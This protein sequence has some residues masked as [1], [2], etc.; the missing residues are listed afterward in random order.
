MRVYFDNA[1]TTP[2]APEVIETVS[3]AMRTLFG[4]PSS[5]HADGR[6][7]RTA[8]ED[9]RKT[10][11]KYLN[12]SIGEIFF[13]SGG[14]ESNNMILKNA[15][16]DLGVK[17]FITSKIEHHCV[18]HTL[19]ALEKTADIQ[20]EF[21]KIDE[22]GQIDLDNLEVLLKINNDKTLVSLMHANNEIG[23]M[24]D[25]D[26]VS[27]ICE[28]NGALFH[29]DT[30]QTMGYFPIDVNKT[31]IHFLTGAAHKFHGPKGIG[32]IYINGDVTLKPFI[33]GGSQER[34]M[35]GG[36]ENVPGIVGLA[37]ALEMAQEDMYERQ[38]EIEG[39][40][41]Y[42][43]NQL[44]DTFADIQF[45][46][47]YE[48]NYHYKVLNVSFPPSMKSEL[49]LFNLDIAG[50]SASGGSACSSGAEGGS[51]VLD[52]LEIDPERKCIR[53]SFSHYNTLDEVDFVIEKLK[54]VVAV[55]MGDKI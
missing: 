24:I 12:A 36:T 11:A 34:N 10:V 29:S 33:D 51:H 8:V 30:V 37:K 35:R 25:L 22:K 26:A 32:F 49:L 17:R 38:D 1:A 53:F 28:E 41:Q 27:K 16:R 9:A 7:A 5:I 47:D 46:G 20:V 43:K 42:F 3:H 19:E 4:N 40:R 52:A 39:I 31:K 54:K 55:K 44:L 6:M 21:V 45:I 13:T 18:L 48:G 23:T 50:I 2:M 14:T 15:V